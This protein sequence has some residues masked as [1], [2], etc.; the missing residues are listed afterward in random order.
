MGLCCSSDSRK[1]SLQDKLLNED[2][3]D[4]KKFSHAPVSKVE[5][6]TFRTS[7]FIHKNDAIITD[8]Y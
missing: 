2:E 7:N 8:V 5:S 6:L 1:Y 3:K 4:M